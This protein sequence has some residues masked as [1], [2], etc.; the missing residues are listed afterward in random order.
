MSNTCRETQVHRTADDAR[1]GRENAGACR[2][3]NVPFHFCSADRFSVGGM[4]GAL[5][6]Q[7]PKG[8]AESDTSPQGIQRV[9]RVF[10]RMPCHRYSLRD[11]FSGRAL[12]A[13]GTPSAAF[14]VSVW[15]H[16]RAVTGARQEC[17]RSPRWVD[18]TAAPGLGR[19][20]SA[21]LFLSL[22]SFQGHAVSEVA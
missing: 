3:Q 13:A 2:Q 17:D 21:F 7:A 9:Y 22:F 16:T 6:T 12:A 5:G 19:Q 4:E 11:A 18:S 8:G 10:W 15:S 1:G 14:C 20:G